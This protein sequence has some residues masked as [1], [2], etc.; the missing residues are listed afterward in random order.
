MCEG[1]P[2]QEAGEEGPP[3][4]RSSQVVLDSYEQLLAHMRKVQQTAPT[5][6]RTFQCHPHHIAELIP[7]HAEW[8]ETIRDGN[9]FWDSVQKGT[10]TEYDNWRDLKHAA[11]SLE[12]AH[13]QVHWNMYGHTRKLVGREIHALWQRDAFANEFAFKLVAEHIGQHI[14]ILEDASV[15]GSTELGAFS[16]LYCPTNAV[17]DQ[18]LV[19]RVYTPGGGAPHCEPLNI[20]VS[21][22]D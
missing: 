15:S 16:V 13:F 1:R 3:A 5:H 20:F 10:V 4:K 14:L 6:V 17:N 11:L 22:R 12:E 7:T 8:Q 19:I 21:L 2:L 9:C 18:V